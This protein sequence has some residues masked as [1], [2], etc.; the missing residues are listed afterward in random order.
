MVTVIEHIAMHITI[1]NTSHMS[2]HLILTTIIIPILQMKI[3]TQGD[4]VTCPRSH[5]KHIGELGGG[6]TRQPDSKIHLL[7]TYRPLSL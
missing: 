3:E 1:L 4:Q 7:T 6:E 2:N 5:S